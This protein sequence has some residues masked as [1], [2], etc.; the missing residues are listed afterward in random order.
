MVISSKSILS[1]LKK[2]IH[3]VNNGA[4]DVVNIPESS[5]TVV[6][7]YVNSENVSFASNRCL[8]P[9][10]PIILHRKILSF[11]KL[12]VDLETVPVNITGLITIHDCIMTLRKIVYTK[13]CMKN[14]SKLTAEKNKEPESVLFKNWEKAPE[15]FKDHQSS[16]YYKGVASLAVIIPSCGDPLSMINQQLAKS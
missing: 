14:V 9:K 1:F 10:K 16:K 6:N 13:Y 11:R 8:L 5:C 12:S 4:D 15:C 2:P 3:T 7:S